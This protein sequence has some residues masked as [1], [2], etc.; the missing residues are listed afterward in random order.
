MTLNTTA[1]E[2]VN[3]RTT[4]KHNASTASCWRKH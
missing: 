4:P 1:L 2:R 3:W